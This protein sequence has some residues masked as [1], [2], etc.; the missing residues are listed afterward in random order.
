[1]DIKKLQ[2]KSDPKIILL[3]EIFYVKY[4]FHEIVLWNFGKYDNIDIEISN[5]LNS[6]Y[7]KY[8]GN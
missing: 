8:L 2:L 1:M 4:I 5:Q 3:I 7:I 6:Y